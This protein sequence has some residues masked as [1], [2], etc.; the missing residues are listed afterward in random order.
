MCEGL[1]VRKFNFFG[2]NLLAKTFSFMTELVSL[3]SSSE[4]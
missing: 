1:D 2:I 4:L 3:I